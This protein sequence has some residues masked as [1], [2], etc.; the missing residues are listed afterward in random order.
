MKRFA[1]DSSS[2]ISLSG[3]CLIR[4]MRN[5]AEG[6]GIELLIARSV[7]QESVERPLKIR[8][9]ELN[10]IRIKD[11]VDSG[12]LKVWGESPELAKI[13][14]EMEGCGNCMVFAGGERMKLIQR[15]EAETV[16]LA[17][18]SGARVVVIDERTTRMLA[19]NP[20]ALR[21]FLQDRH[22]MKIDIDSSALGRLS[23]LTSGMNFIRSSELLAL[24]YE[25]N[26]FGPELQPTKQSL[27]AALYAVKFA[28][29][30]V[31]NAEIERYLKEVRQ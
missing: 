23:A 5:L 22:N 16:A 6:A 8:R 30:A 9:F 27:E 21:G 12:Y 7:Y 14:G 17:K 19:E 25:R 3:N 13:T 2:L 29:C 11:A 1:V 18:V 15:G 26:L 20:Y 31:S 4:I 24:A 28:G 10:A